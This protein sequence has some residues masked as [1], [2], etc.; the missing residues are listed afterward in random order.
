LHCAQ[1][2]SAEHDCDAYTISIHSHAPQRAATG[3][4]YSTG[5]HTHS[6]Q[7]TRGGPGGARTDCSALCAAAE[8]T[9]RHCTHGDSS[10]KYLQVRGAKGRS[11]KGTT[12]GAE[13]G[14]G[15]KM[16]DKGLW[17]ARKGIWVNG[18]LQ[19]KSHQS[20]TKGAARLAGTTS[21][22]R[23]VQ[24][25]KLQDPQPAQLRTRQCDSKTVHKHAAQC[26]P[27]TQPTTC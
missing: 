9:G 8:G 12:H 17:K 6:K 2:P 18:G 14:C 3:Q 10:H 21:C 25:L 22:G 26:K 5:G 13:T 24:P 1:T 7:D 19:H 20:D 23:P 11:L 15:M 4:D 27:Y 16:T